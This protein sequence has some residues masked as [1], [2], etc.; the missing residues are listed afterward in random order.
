VTLRERFV[1]HFGRPSPNNVTVPFTL[2]GPGE[3]TPLRT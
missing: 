1:S 2:L 3:P